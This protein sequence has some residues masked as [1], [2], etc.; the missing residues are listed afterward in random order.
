MKKAKRINKKTK[1]IKRKM[2]KEEIK[3]KKAKI[4]KTFFSIIIVIIL[5]FLT[6]MINDYIIQDKNKTTNL[7][8][9]NEN[10]TSNLK[11][12]ILIEDNIIYLSK[13]DIATFFDKYI[14][15]EEE[16]NQIITTYDKK[17]AAIGFDRNE[18]TINGSKKEIYA[19]AIERNN[20][21][22]VPV[23]EM[24][25]V[26][27]IEIENIQDT[28][29]ITI[30]SLDKEQRKA[31]VSSN[32]PIKYTTNLISK[33]ID[34]VKKGDT[35]I[36]ISSEN[37]NTKVRT[38]SGK[39]GYIKSNK[40]E[41]EYTVR[42]N[43]IEEKQ[44]Q[45]QINLKVDNFPINGQVPNRT[46]MSIENINVIAPSFLYIDANG[47]LKEN[48]GTSGKAY[49]EWAHNNKCKIWSTLSISDELKEETLN[50]YEKRESLIEEI[51]MV[52]AKY[53]LNGV[54]I[55]F[56]NLNQENKDIYTRLI[57]ELTPRLQEIGMVTSLY[58]TKY[59]EG[60]GLYFD[61][62]LIKNVVNF[63]IISSDNN[64][65]Y[66]EQIDKDKVIIA[67]SLS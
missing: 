52:C 35:V 48:I 2:S 23:S 39:I 16:S 15:V 37:G 60:E 40:L 56:Q 55:N 47:N 53:E 41:N 21:K 65:N 19:H 51:V 34:R 33:T 24:K 45:G 59:E 64:I 43:M 8:I 29:V 13:D 1:K 36:V 31:I 5:I 7:V 14:Y 28:K 58:I 42:E 49:I 12:D 63:I 50:S 46:Q 11:N 54:N 3:R 17:I 66:T 6:L 18:V 10:V 61:N 20:I 4:K 38:P 26:Y 27:N 44:V 9:N 30:D 25:N 57:I 67:T 62:E 22:Y 32:L